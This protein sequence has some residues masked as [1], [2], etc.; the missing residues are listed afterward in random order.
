MEY[1][2]HLRESFFDC[3]TKFTES[4]QNLIF[5]KIEYLKMDD[6]NRPRSL[7]FKK[8]QGTDDFYEGSVSMGIRLIFMRIEDRIYITEVGRHDIFKKY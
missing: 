5:R 1:K 3:L 6:V 7:R 4:E 2:I 8:V